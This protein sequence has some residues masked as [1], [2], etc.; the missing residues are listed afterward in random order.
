MAIRP[1]TEQLV[2]YAE[3]GRDGEVVMLNLL[4]F[5]ERADDGEGSGAEAYS[6]Y[7]DAVIEMVEARGGRIVWLGRAEHVFIGD[8]DAND[9]D[10]V[11][12]VSYPSR[13]AFLEMVS[14]PEYDDIHRHREGGLERTV[15]IGCEP[16][17]DR[18]GRGV[19]G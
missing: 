6:R 10:A 13:G 14:T 8:V 18:A 5:K 7:S 16:Q 2:E 12:L 11:A 3:H 17:L 15:V 9:W 4:K 19:R 1:N